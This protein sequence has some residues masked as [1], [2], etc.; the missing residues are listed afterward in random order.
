[1]FEVTGYNKFAFRNSFTGMRQLY[2]TSVRERTILFILKVLFAEHG[3]LL[4][5]TDWLRLFERPKGGDVEAVLPFA[6]DTAFW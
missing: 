1:M 2:V 6:R 4:C 3:T 5:R